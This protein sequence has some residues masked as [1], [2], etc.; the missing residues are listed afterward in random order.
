MAGGTPPGKPS[1]PTTTTFSRLVS[2]TLHYAGVD[3]GIDFTGAGD[4]Y[5]PAKALVTRVDRGGTG[6]PGEGALVALKLLDG[7][8]AGKYVYYA[9]D[10]APTVKRGQVVAAGT[11]VARATGSGKA[12]GVEIGWAT[13]A[14]SPLAPRPPHRPAPQWTQLGQDFHDWIQGLSGA[15]PGHTLPGDAGGVAKH[16]PGVQQAADVAGFLGKLTDPSYLLRGLQIVAGA[17]LMLAGLVLLTRQVALA[18]DIPTPPLPTAAGAALA[19][20]VS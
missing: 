5:A 10:L 20:A 6:W 7:P 4:L 1:D 8:G 2:A 12:P 9:E 18:A 11:I 15:R 14:G 16:V 19:K 3:Q 13:P 17:V